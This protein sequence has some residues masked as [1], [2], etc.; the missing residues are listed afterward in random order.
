MND[1]F[2]DEYPDW[3]PSWGQPDDEE[4][5]VYSHHHNLETIWHFIDGHEWQTIQQDAD[6]G[7]IDSEELVS[8]IL[9]RMESAIFFSKMGEFHPRAVSEAKDLADL[10]VELIE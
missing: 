5:I 1:N 2:E 9:C 10:V 8:T 6:D 4:R 3:R 7:C